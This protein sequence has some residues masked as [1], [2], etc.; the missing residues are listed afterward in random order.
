MTAV[1]TPH[2][3]MQNIW[4][5]SR[6]TWRLFALRYVPLVAAFNFVWEVLQL[7]L[8]TIWRDASAAEIAYAVAHCTLGDIGIGGFALLAALAVVRPGPP[9]SWP[10][11]RVGGLTTALAVAYTMYSEW[12]NTTVREAWAYSELMP[13]L[14]VTGIGLSPLAQWLVIPTLALLLSSRLALRSDPH[15]SP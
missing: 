13:V 5:R 7:P 10:L 8:Y 2:R 3:A 14:P 6:A 4:F 1:Y 15:P 11:A 9:P 12:L